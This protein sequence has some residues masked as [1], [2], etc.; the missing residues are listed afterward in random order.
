MLFFRD[1][2]GGFFQVDGL[3]LSRRMNSEDM[4]EAL[5]EFDSFKPDDVIISTYPKTG[6]LLL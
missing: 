1:P 3:K 4:I 6:R 5:K 2:E